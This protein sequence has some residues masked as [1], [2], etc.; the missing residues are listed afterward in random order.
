MAQAIQ[1]DA[2]NPFPYYRYMR[3][4]DPVHFNAQ[5]GSWEVF[6][7]NEVQQVLSDYATFSSSIMGQGGGPTHLLGVSMI[8]TDPPRHR[9]LRSLT[10]QAFT[11]RAVAR[12]SDRIEELV[13]EML[14]RV[15]PAGKMDVIEDLSYPLPVMV[16]AE[17][18]G[19]PTEDR[20]RF[21]K[22]SDAVVS[23]TY[24]SSNSQLEMGQYFRKI[25]EQRRH[26]PKD[27]L[28]SDL[29]AAQVDGQH[30]SEMEVLGFCALLLVAGNETTTNLIGNAILCF[31]AHPEIYDQ[32]RA[33][34]ELLTGAIEE[35]LR[36]LSPV[37]FMY[38]MASKDVTL[39]GKQIKAGQSVIAW[40]G[41]ANRDD[42]QFENADT[43]DIRRANAQRHIAFG[44]GIHYCLGAPLARLEAKIA[45]GAMLQRLPNLKRD[46]NKPLAHIDSP[47]MYGV[48]NLPV[49]FG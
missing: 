35:V 38:R 15:L 19:V 8:T 36:Y 46:R 24:G 42:T 21:K 40:I 10:T 13:D 7:Y 45:L 30:L 34:P 47:I 3:Q 23:F 11:P 32:L 49:T 29:L 33:E 44:H 4:S 41:S 12:L 17:M 31:D 48:K 43:F 6:S 37:Q 25:V 2:L 9:Q 28:I 39:A 20:A 26:E 27:D 16:I 1:M 5:Y 14:T 22:W 18:L